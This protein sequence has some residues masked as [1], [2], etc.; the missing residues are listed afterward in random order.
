M[1]SVVYQCSGQLECLQWID[2]ETKMAMIA[3]KTPRITR[4]R[5]VPGPLCPIRCVSQHSHCAVPAGLNV[6][7]S[8]PDP[9]MRIG[10]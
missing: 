7:A 2:F 6:P 1:R 10:T 4:T 8:K 9:G 3:T 5:S